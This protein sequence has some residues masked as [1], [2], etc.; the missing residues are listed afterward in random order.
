MEANK[1]ADGVLALEKAVATLQREAKEV[2]GEFE[3]KLSE[4]EAD[5]SVIQEVGPRL[6]HLAPFPVDVWVRLGLTAAMLP[7]S[8]SS[9][10]SE[11]P[12][13][14]WPG[15]GGHAGDIECPGRAAASDE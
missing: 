6:L 11:G 2:D 7:S 8:D 4:V 1:T 14:G 5:A 13:Q 15:T 9:G 12:H 10:S 3:R